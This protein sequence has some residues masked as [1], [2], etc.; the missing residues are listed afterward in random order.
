MLITLIKTWFHFFLSCMTTDHKQIQV[1]KMSAVIKIII[2]CSNFYDQKPFSLP[3][4]PFACQRLSETRPFY[5]RWNHAYMLPV[6]VTL[7]T[8]TSTR[9][10]TFLS[11]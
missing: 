8:E 7:P 10:S 1:T 9:I 3:F 11:R 6:D 2:L 5:H 4:G